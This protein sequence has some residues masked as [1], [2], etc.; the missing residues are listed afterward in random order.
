MNETGHMVENM[1]KTNQKTFPHCNYA[2]SRYA[3]RIKWG[4]RGSSSTATGISEMSDLILEP[5]GSIHQI[6][7][8]VK[9]Y[10]DAEDVG[11]ILF[12][13][14]TRETTWWY[15]SHTEKDPEGDIRWWNLLPTKET[16]KVSPK[17][18]KYKLTIF[19]D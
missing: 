7:G 10:N 16:I 9:L 19:N 1:T 17:T 11:L 6:D 13:P 12:N 2:P 18:S 15:V 8:F 5:G 14:A 3:S 4:Q